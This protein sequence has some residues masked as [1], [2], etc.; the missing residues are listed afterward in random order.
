[1]YM[2]WF[3]VIFIS[4]CVGGIMFSSIIPKLFIKK[5]ITSLSD[6]LNPGAYNAFK[7]SGKRIGTVCLLLDFFKGF[8]PVF[9]VILF[10]DYK[11]VLFLLV[12]IAPVL[13]HS[14]GV[15]NHFH[16]GK[17]I[18]TSFGVLAA[19]ARINFWPLIFLASLYVFF[20]LII[21][22]ESNKTKSIIVYS[23]LII[24]V[25][26]ML[27]NNFNY[28]AIGV[29]VI[30]IIVIIKHINLKKILNNKLLKIND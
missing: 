18:T 22:I 29:I 6:D 12:M 30:S 28:Y 8:I 27:A 1:M 15:F 25:A 19:I 10:M 2:L 14:F 5:D 7:Y 16:G 9:L 4:F 17:C 24:F 3:I 20:S 26:A 23:S 11:N 13:G 21:K